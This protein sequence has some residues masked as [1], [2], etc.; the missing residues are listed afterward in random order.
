M[1]LT[2]REKHLRARL[3]EVLQAARLRAGLTTIRAASR[4]SGVSHP[5]ISQIEAGLRG[6]SLLIIG[7]LAKPY[8]VPV[9][10]LLRR[11]GYR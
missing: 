4:A 10:T 1:E 8:R 7:R 2:K 9:L 5:L 11:A 6:P 3:G